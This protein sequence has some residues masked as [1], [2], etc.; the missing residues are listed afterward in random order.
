MPVTY[1]SFFRSRRFRRL[2][3]QAELAAVIGVPI[4]I[5]VVIEWNDGIVIRNVAVQQSTLSFQLDEQIAQRSGQDPHGLV[6]VTVLIAVLRSKKVRGDGG[7]SQR[8]VG[9]T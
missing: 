2:D 6:F 5:T 8:R 9:F 7:R 3:T 1:R 4:H